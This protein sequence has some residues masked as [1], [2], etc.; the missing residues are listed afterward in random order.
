MDSPYENLPPRNF[1]RS[2]VVGHSPGVADDI[3]VAKFPIKRSYNVATAGSCFA[4]HIG[5]YLKRTGC[6]ILDVEPPP[7]AMSDAIARKYGYGIYSARYGNIYT[8]RQLLQ[9][10]R[11]CSGQFTPNN[12]IWT[13]GDAFIDGLRPSV[14]PKGLTRPDEVVA[15]RAQHLAAVKLLFSRADLLIF[16]MGLTE[17]WVD[18]PSGT[19]FPTAPGTLGGDFATSRCK[20][21]N[22]TFREIYDDFIATREALK[23]INPSLRFI[24]TVSPVPLTAT[25]TKDHVLV[26]TMRSK[27]TLRA[28]A[29]ELSAELDDV[30]YFPS[31]EMVFGPQSMGTFFEPNLRSV[32]ANGVAQ[33]MRVFLKAHGLRD[34]G[35]ADPDA[36][37]R[38]V[39]AA[40]TAQAFEDELVC[41]EVLLEAFAR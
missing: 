35:D 33:V 39:A 13:K 25:A 19:V 24:L 38:P 26:A 32:R 14:E 28:V 27:A 29:G 30:D 10:V 31:F 16:T 20:F 9:L 8:V 40:E 7:P 17:A 18:A 4:Q 2:G 11:E 12:W 1:W 6:N 3:Y 23:A 21:H 41:E 36:P 34:A 22:F 15:H 5:S 37:A